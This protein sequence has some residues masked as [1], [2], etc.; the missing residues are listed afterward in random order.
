MPESDTRKR[1]RFQN[2]VVAEAV[3]VFSSEYW[4]KDEK[5]TTVLP[6]IT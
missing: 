1:I 4:R 3:E 5:A 2:N 6:D